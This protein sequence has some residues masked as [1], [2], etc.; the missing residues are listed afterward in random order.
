MRGV[1]GGLSS[2]NCVGD[3]ASSSWWRWPSRTGSS[4]VNQAFARR[5]GALLWFESIEDVSGRGSRV[6]FTGSS[7]ATTLADPDPD[8]APSA[9]QVRRERRRGRQRRVAGA[10]LRGRQRLADLASRSPKR[11][12]R[13]EA[14]GTSTQRAQARLRREQ[15]GAWVPEVNVSMAS[16]GCT[17]LWLS[18]FHRKMAVFRPSPRRNH[19]VGDATSG[20][21][22]GERVRGARARGH[23]R[24]GASIGE[25]LVRVDRPSSTLEGAPDV[26]ACTPQPRVRGGNLAMSVGAPP[27]GDGRRV[28]DGRQGASEVGVLRERLLQPTRRGGSEPSSP[29]HRDA[30]GSPRSL[31][32]R[33]ER[34]LD[35]ALPPLP[36]H[37]AN[38]GGCCGVSTRPRRC[39]VPSGQMAHGGS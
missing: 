17:H 33:S 6:P 18:I 20:E 10:G 25:R 24:A 30:T 29:S 34:W 21:V 37:R 12:P 35:T 15:V 4:R 26:L 32:D 16:I 27:F 38:G 14:R 36:R 31:D 2:R 23:T 11:G 28:I 19:V 7:R 22:R 5:P 13:R 39:R 1:A 8:N 9:R 3:A